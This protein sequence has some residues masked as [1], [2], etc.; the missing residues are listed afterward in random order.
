MSEQVDTVDAPAEGA[1]PAAD[2][3]TN[4][5][6][7]DLLGGS[8]DFNESFVEDSTSSG[9][10]IDSLDE[11]YR[12]NTSINKYNSMDDFIDGHLNMKS[13]IGKKGLAPLSE[14]ATPEEKNE[15]YSRIGRPETHEG[16]DWQSPTIEV[17]NDTGEKEEVPMVNIDQE[18]MS[19]TMKVFH[20]NGL[21][22]NQAK[23]VMDMFAEHEHA[24]FENGLNDFANQQEQTAQET[25]SQLLQEWGDKFDSK[26]SA[27]NNVVNKF[28]LTETLQDLGLAN[29]YRVVKMFESMISK[30]GEGQITGDMS[31]T[32]GG[33]EEAVSAIRQS[34]AYQN[35]MH[36]GHHEANQRLESLYK[37]KYG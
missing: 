1:A 25:K 15:F 26:L 19:E 16:Y 28:G 36:P 21:T 12:E 4:I 18:L 31:P 14:D 20:E 3:N 2:V 34:E 5:P 33:F 17:E 13:L 10:W 8:G 37:R 29:D 23:A 9:N 30:V 24:R 32:G 22:N 11:K 27:V 35:P 6:S 7:G